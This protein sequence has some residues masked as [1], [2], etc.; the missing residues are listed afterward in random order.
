M[1]SSSYILLV[2]VAA[3]VA[4]KLHTK[5]P[6]P[7][8]GNQTPFGIGY[9]ITAFKAI[10]QAP[11]LIEEGLTKYHG[12]PFVLPTLGGSVLLTSNKA[13][14]EL[15]RKSD[16]STVNPGPGPCSVVGNAYALLPVEPTY[17]SKRGLP[18][19]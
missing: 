18:L 6:F 5:R 1:G 15:M 19:F 11:E 9:L 14:A 2:A 4:I 10:T 12:K 8:V 3:A 7:R 13:D 16:D 17:C